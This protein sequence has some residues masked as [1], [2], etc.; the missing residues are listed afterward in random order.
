MARMT[1]RI[2][3]AI[4]I[5]LGVVGFFQSFDTIF[6]LTINHNVVHLLSGIVLLSLSGTEERSKLGAK[7]VGSIYLLMFITGLFTH[8]IAGIMLMPMDDVLH[9]LIA[10]VLLFV[11]FKTP[12]TVQSSQSSTIEK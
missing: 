8:T 9:V 4:F 10:A 3:G 7:I 5:I 12:A 6:S 11:G 1:T 2:L